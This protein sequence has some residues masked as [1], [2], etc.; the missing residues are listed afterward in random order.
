MAS[1]VILVGTDGGILIGGQAVRSS[2]PLVI[3]T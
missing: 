3:V 2:S 1:G